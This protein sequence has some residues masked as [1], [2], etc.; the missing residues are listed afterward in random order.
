MATEQRKIMLNPAELMAALRAFRSANPG[1]IPPG[2]IVECRCEDDHVA[3]DIRGRDDVGP[4]NFSHRLSYESMCDV[5]IRFCIENNVPLPR[6]GKKSVQRDANTVVL[7]I[8]MEDEMLSAAN[9][10]TDALSGAKSRTVQ[11][12]TARA[13]PQL[14]HAT[15]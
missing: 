14:A 10:V 12:A 9:Y 5:L 4:R 8:R 3:L 7:K 11:P 15:G 1:R 2:E 13:A 6:R